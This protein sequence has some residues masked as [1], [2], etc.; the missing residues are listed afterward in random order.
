MT[1]PGEKLREFMK[2]F[3]GPKSQQAFRQVEG[4]I[5]NPG[6]VTGVKRKKKNI[7]PFDEAVQ[8]YENKPKQELSVE[9][10]KAISNFSNQIGNKSLA[11]QVYDKKKEKGKRKKE[12]KRLDINITED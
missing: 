1:G 6:S 2:K 9:D 5:T 7:I 4:S 8:M 3:I 11:E 10:A 12:K